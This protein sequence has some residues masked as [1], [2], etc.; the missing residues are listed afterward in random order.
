[1]LVFQTM[2]TDLTGTELA[3]ASLLDEATAAAEAMTLARR[4]IKGAGSTFVVDADVLG[5]TLAVLRT[6]AEPLGID[7]VVA[8]LEQGLPEGDDVF[9]VLVQYPTAGG[10]V[11]DPRAVI[12]AAHERGALAVVAADPLALTLLRAPGEMGADIVVGSAQRFGVPMA[13]GGPHAG[14]MAVKEG[15]QRQLPGRL[16]GVSVDNAGT[17]AYRLALQTREQHIRREKATSNICTAQV[18]LAVIAGTYAVYHGPEGL[19]AIARRVHARTAELAEGLRVAGAE[20][21]HA[22]FFDTLRGRVP[23]R[24]GSGVEAARA[25][26]VNLLLVDADTVGISCDEATTPEHVQ[27]VLRAFGAE[28]RTGDAATTLPTALRREQDYLTH[29]VFHEHR[30][31][32]SLLRYLRRLADRDLALDR[33]MIPLGSCTMK[34]NAAAE[35]IP[36]SCPRYAVFHPLSTAEQE[37]RY[38]QMMR[39]LEGMLAEITGFAAV[40]LQPNSGAQGE[41]AGLLVIRARHR[42]S[43]QG[44]RD[45]CRLLRYATSRGFMVTSGE[46]Q[47]RQFS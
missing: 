24:A 31:E 42:A 15:L 40:S 33:T 47:R 16:V 2:V 32:T 19:R 30:S 9:G 21:L 20:V 7:I 37:Q 34:L 43:G 5:Q 44:D 39:E 1:L 3:N 35:L 23:A 13:F 11:R 26:G 29:P 8:D 38:V 22:E 4:S 41:L 18:L 27:A 45:V 36:I 12:E 46:L 25:E 10:A 17:P 6:R 14:Y 28:G